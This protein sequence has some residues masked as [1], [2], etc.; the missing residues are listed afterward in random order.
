MNN[1]AI[2]I[3]AY[4]RQ[5]SL[6]RLLNSIHKAYYNSNAINLIISI[7]HSIETEVYKLANDFVWKNGEKR[8]LKRSKHLGLKQH[9]LMCADLVQ[10]FESVIILEDDLVVSPFF[11]EYA[12]QAKEFYKLDDNIAGIS[13]YNYQVTENN[14]YPFQALNDGS[15]VYFM[16]LAS[17]WGQL[18]TK[19]QWE[20]F[21]QWFKLNPEL[22][23]EITTPDYIKV[24]GNNSWK[25]HYINYLC[26]TNKYF[27]FPQLSLTTNFE[28][29]GTNS[30]TSNVFHTPIQVLQHPYYF[31]N[32][33]ESSS[34][35]D[36][37]FE[38]NPEVLKS[39]NTNLK[40][41]DFEVDLH[42]A[43]NVERTNAPY[44]LTSKRSSNPVISFSDEL[45]PL[46]NNIALNLEG[47][48]I[49]LFDKNNLF[50][51]V[52][53]SYRNSSL[54]F[55][56][57]SITFVIP[58]SEENRTDL[59]K[60]INSIAVQN[61]KHIKILLIVRKDLTRPAIEDLPCDGIKTRVILTNYLLLDELIL[62][63]IKLS[64]SKYTCWLKPGSILEKNVLFKVIDVFSISQSIK[65]IK[66]ISKTPENH[67]DYERLDVNELRISIR[68]LHSRNLK[69]I[70][71]TEG[72]FIRSNCYD[73]LNV[74]TSST[75]EVYLQLLSHFNLQIV[76][77]TFFKSKSNSDS[78][79]RLSPQDL[80]LMEKHRIKH[81][82]NQ[83][84]LK[85]TEEIIKTK[86]LSTK[87]VSRWKEIVD[88]NLEDVIRYNFKDDFFYLS[89]F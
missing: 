39:L 43:K 12:L 9:I 10:E 5:Y 65:W 78:V 55:T 41:Y 45:F 20:N 34:I 17:S 11:Y 18:F 71:T 35:Y 87:E 50:E 76:L 42:G 33:S 85:K 53:P 16:Q 36:A 14:F 21:R 1:P 77:Y 70:Q 13:L 32:L 75:F 31:K 81:K 28:D 49:G 73:S 89:K 66:G 88:N 38:L 22:T 63:G 72:D 6:E 68:N 58:L 80:S 24:W 51:S 79:F 57:E 2:V 19:E 74:S 44:I 61:Y 47:N 59:I 3:V 7:D 56:S 40:K 37:N 25:K 46:E 15:S 48:G 52:K 8:I 4:N 83:P 84:F 30:R 29:E 27:V 60:T 69:R 23:D 62:H 54:K 86:L 26:S 82:R 67:Y 64:N